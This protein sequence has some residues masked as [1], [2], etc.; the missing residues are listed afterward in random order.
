MFESKRKRLQIFDIEGYVVEK[1]PFTTISFTKKNEINIHE[2][3]DDD[4]L[5]FILWLQKGIFNTFFLF[6][7]LFY[8]GLFTLW[9]DT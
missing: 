1:S 7:F 3:K 9:F 6:W 4:D 2:D 8:L 5:C